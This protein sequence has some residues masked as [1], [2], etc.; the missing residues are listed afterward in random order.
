[1]QEK[2]RLSF[3][4][5]IVLFSLCVLSS[6]SAQAQ[7]RQAERYEIV[8][9]YSDEDFTIIPLKEDGLALFRKKFKFND[10]NRIWELI[11]LDSA[12]T[13]K[14]TMELE[15]DN[16]GELTGYEHSH[17][18]VHLLFVKNEMRGDMEVISVNLSTY[19]FQ[20]IK[21][22]TELKINLTHFNKCGDNFILGGD[23]G[24]EPA[25]FVYIPSTKHFKIIPGFFK[26][27]TELIDVRVNDNQ[28]FNT[29]LISRENRDNNKIIFRTFDSFGKQLIE[30]VVSIKGHNLQTGISSNLQ[31]D[32]LMILGTWG[33]TGASQSSGFYGVPVNP[34]SEQEIKFTFLGQLNHYLDHTKPKRAEKIKS[35]TKKAIEEGGDPDFSNHIIPHRIIEHEKGFIL[36]AETYVPSKDNYNSR[37]NPYAYSY[38][39][40][41]SRY[42]SY[43]PGSGMYNTNDGRYYGDNVNNA[44]EIRT[45]QSQ[46]ILFTPTG[47]VIADYSIDLDD[48]KMPTLNQITDF[49]LDKDDL[50]FFYKKES[51]LIIKKINLQDGQVSESTQKVKMK[52]PMDVIRS[53]GKDSRIRHL[54]GKNFYMYGYQSVKFEDGQSKD[55]F[56]INRV[57][58]D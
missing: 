46:V 26:K 14:K 8:Q 51:D 49:Y 53:E 55:I 17:G 29:L 7:V 6:V 15:V 41:G 23:V 32:D 4:I 22:T 40:Y 47:E 24:E 10:R 33:N 35:R 36:L 12:V 25:V 30:D 58:I 2:N 27:R 37:S 3:M 44:I 39:P 1:M 21:I 19:E 28:T 11:L 56:Y 54:Y 42:G 5:R 18:F 45:V 31:R 20:R 38:N 52:S 16:Q 48:I 13:E 50:Y 57:A 9:R 34:F 43:Y